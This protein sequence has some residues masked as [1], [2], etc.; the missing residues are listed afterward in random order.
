MKREWVNGWHR[1]C[2]ADHALSLDLGDAHARLLRAV[3]AGLAVALAALHLEHANLLGLGLRLDDAGD[4]GAGDVGR[5]GHDVAAVVLDEQHLVERHFGAGLDVQ[6]ID[7]HDDARRDLFLPAPG[8]NNG[9]HLQTPG[10]LRA[11]R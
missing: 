8:F 6:P 4:D 5:A 1:P 9:E 10:R 2:H 7:D 3:A 11:R